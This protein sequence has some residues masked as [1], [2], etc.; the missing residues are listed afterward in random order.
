MPY[1]CNGCSVAGTMKTVIKIDTHNSGQ[2]MVD[3]DTLKEET[4]DT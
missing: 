2:D 4:V 3:N 1:A